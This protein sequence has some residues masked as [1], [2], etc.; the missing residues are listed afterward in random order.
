[1]VSGL[2]R[3]DNH[4]QSVRVTEPRPQHAAGG[5]LASGLRNGTLDIG[6]Q[7]LRQEIT[8]QRI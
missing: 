6:A 8:Y 5:F 1:M 3:Q 2:A 7:L 4:D